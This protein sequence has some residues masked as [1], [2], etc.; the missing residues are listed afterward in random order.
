[1]HYQNTLLRQYH[2]WN[3]EIARFALRTKNKAAKQR[4][5]HA[6]MFF[7]T[8]H[9]DPEIQKIAEQPLIRKNQSLMKQEEKNS[10]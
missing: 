5:S 3:M 7:F 2:F 6:S 10:F 1:M 8:P 4:H 9:E